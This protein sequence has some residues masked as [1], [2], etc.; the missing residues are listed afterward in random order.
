MCMGRHPS[1]HTTKKV[2]ILVYRIT[3]TATT[4]SIKEVLTFAARETVEGSHSCRNST[5]STWPLEAARCMGRHPSYYTTRKVYI[6]V[7][8]ITE[9]AT[10]E[11]I[12]EVLTLAA[13]ETVEGS[14][15]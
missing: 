2:Y 6:L 7:Y 3:E 12:K 9:T 14:H 5:T 13:R 11:S 4:E 15:F 1:C 10:T 8:R